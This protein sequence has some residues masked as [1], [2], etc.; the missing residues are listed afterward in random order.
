[1]AVTSNPSANFTPRISFGNW[2]DHQTAPTAA[3]LPLNVANP[4]ILVARCNVEH[5][6]DFKRFIGFR[7]YAQNVREGASE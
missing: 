3:P 6:I 7:R 5:T 2:Y 1:L 4:L